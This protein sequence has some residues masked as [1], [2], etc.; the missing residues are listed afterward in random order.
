MVKDLIES[1]IG[2]QG[3]LQVK[4]PVCFACFDKILEQLD[5]KIKNKEEERVIYDQQLHQL[6]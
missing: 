4:Y 5:E 6:E 1:N 3:G 2:E